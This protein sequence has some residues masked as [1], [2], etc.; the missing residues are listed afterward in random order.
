MLCQRLMKAKKRRRPNPSRSSST[1]PIDLH[2]DGWPWAHALSVERK[3]SSNGSGRMHGS[4][5]LNRS[6]PRTSSACAVTRASTGRRANGVSADAG[7]VLRDSASRGMAIQARLAPIWYVIACR[8][9][10]V[11]S[12]IHSSVRTQH[13]GRWEIEQAALPL[14][15]ATRKQSRSH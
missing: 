14:D 10:W 11:Q 1:S 2:G 9:A 4:R 6:E 15:E 12:Y 7:D 5:R 3:H 13:R 8:N